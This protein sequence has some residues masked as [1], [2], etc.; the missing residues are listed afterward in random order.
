MKDF[1]KMYVIATVVL[2]IGSVTAIIGAVMW[3]LQKTDLLS[4]FAGVALI[5]ASLPIYVY[6]ALLQEERTEEQKKKVN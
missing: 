5:F 6:G 1:R 4:P 3:S 2:T